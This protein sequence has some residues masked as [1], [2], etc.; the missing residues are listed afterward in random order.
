MP[1]VL[2]TVVDGTTDYC[3]EGDVQVVLVDF[4]RHDLNTSFPDDVERDIAMVRALPDMPWATETIRRLAKVRNA[5][6]TGIRSE[7]PPPEEI[8]L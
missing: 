3:T 4:D 1:A 2:I 6:S 8:P 7:P 5:I